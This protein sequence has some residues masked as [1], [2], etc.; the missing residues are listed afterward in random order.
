MSLKKPISLLK[1]RNFLLLWCAYFI[2]A[3]GDHLSEMEILRMQ[4]ALGEGVDII[5]LQARMMFVF[6]I[7]FFLF[8]PLMGML[9]DRY[10]RRGLMIFAD[11]ARIALMLFFATLI[12][13]LSPYSADWGPYLPLLFV[14]L[15]AAMFSPARSAMLPTLIE[16]EQLVEANALIRGV[17]VLATIISAVLGGWLAD[18]MPGVAFKADAAT[19]AASAILV[20]FII[21]PKSDRTQ[22]VREERFIPQIAGGV[23]YILCHRRVM[24]LIIFGTVYWF[25]AAGLN[26]IVPAV[27]KHSF[28]LKSYQ[29]VSM[30]RAYL[31]VGMVLGSGALFVLKDALRSEVAITWSLIGA[32]LAGTLMAVS[33]ISWWSNSVAYV[34][35][36]IGIMVAGFF[37]SGLIT[38][39]NAL[40]QRI[41]PDRYRGRVYGVLDL[42]T[43]TGLLLACGVL[44]IPHWEKIDRWCGLIA[45][46]IGMLMLAVGLTSLVIRHT[47]QPDPI[48]LS[49]TRGFNEF[50]CRFWYKLKRVGPCTVPREGPVIITANHSATPDPLM[51][52]AECHHRRIS[53]L[54]AK[55]YTGIPV[56][57][58]FIG[59]I[60]CI[61]VERDANDANSA[62]E[63]LRRLK[64]GDALGIFIEGRIPDPGEV[65]EPK[66]GVAMLALRSG[67]TVIPVGISG[68]VFRDGIAAGFFAPHRA[69]IRFGEPVDLSEFP[70]KPSHEELNAAT[71]KIHGA[72]LDLVTSSENP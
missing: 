66:N 62:R 19:F 44:G 25:S 63:A 23:R 33:T 22:V 38:S 48:G 10:P 45:M 40:L 64:N 3:M 31:V 65:A 11:I 20:F 67:A 26:S 53:F 47:N 9:A 4:N 71:K 16:D 41:V 61:P 34:L 8:G 5:P 18:N 32:G 39:Y 57:K 58:W 36:A 1:N 50:F 7:P 30:F 42:C 68:T 24:Q 56:A 37:G 15:F 13:W 54:V 27:V 43:M 28:G 51:I 29:D 70:S 35:G 60:A 46:G 12:V 17:G 72:I 21:A 2:S 49:I 52:Y 69:T 55:E 14:G 6:F 59:S